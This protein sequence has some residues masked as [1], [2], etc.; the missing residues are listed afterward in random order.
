M[1]ISAVESAL[2]SSANFDEVVVVGI[3]YDSGQIHVNTSMNYQPDVYFALQ[4]AARLMLETG[5]PLND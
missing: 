5:G 2:L 3:N 1:E 4:S